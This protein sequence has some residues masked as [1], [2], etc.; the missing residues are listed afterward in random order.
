MS[1]LHGFIMPVTGFKMPTFM[2]SSKKWLI[3]TPNS[4]KLALSSSGTRAEFCQII[5]VTKILIISR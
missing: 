1:E 5:E 4:L 2:A 3:C